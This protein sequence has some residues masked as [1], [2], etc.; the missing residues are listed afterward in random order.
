MS[1]SFIVFGLSLLMISEP[2]D[3]RSVAR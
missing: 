3:E 2:D 1:L